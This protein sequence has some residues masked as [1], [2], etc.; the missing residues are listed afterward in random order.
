M[1]E[2][3]LPAILGNKPEPLLLIEP[4][5]FP[6]RHCFDRLP[7]YFC[8]RQS[9]FAENKKS[10]HSFKNCAAFLFLTENLSS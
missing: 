2:S 3:I 10:R 8:Q 9:I 4:L 5:G 1:H 6:F 7:Q